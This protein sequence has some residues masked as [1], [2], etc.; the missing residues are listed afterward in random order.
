MTELSVTPIAEG[1]TADAAFEA[2]AGTTDAAF[3]LDG[4]NSLPSY[5]GVGTTVELAPPILPGLRRAFTSMRDTDRTVLGLVGWLSYDLGAETVGL[6]I[7][8]ADGM[9][10]SFMEV[11]ETLAIDPNGTVSLI[12]RH[13]SSCKLHA[14]IREIREQLSRP[15]DPT[16]SEAPCGVVDSVRWD[17]TD[18]EYADKIIKCQ[19]HIRAGDA[20][21][22]CL[23][24]RITVQASMEPLSVYRRLRQSNGTSRSGI[25]RIGDT[26]ILSTSPEQFL[27]VNEH[28]VISTSPI[29]GT[30]PRSD[31]PVE[32]EC[33]RIELQNNLKERAENIMI[34]DLMRN[35]LSRVCD[36]GTVTVTRLLEVE[37]H[38]QVHQ[39]VSTVEGQLR[40][41]NDT[42]DALAVCF[43][44][45]SMTG[46]PKKRA[47]ELLQ[48]LECGPRGL[49]AGAF[50][51]IRFDGVADFSMTIRTIVCT[52]DTAV[53]GTGGGITA[54]SVP[55]QEVNEI[56]LKARA[57][58]AAIEARA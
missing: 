33:L 1:I 14:R 55:Q 6:E 28:R 30:R 58:I 17:D 45:G 10:T 52:R 54:L 42:V 25:I 48:H 47:M 49:Y 40:A 12:T 34:V 20:Y 29:K 46:A 38:P 23:T 36:T 18:N 56:H 13:R 57:L 41:D 50:G 3:W 15:P 8:Q 43:P 35:D 16:L 5:V 32:D 37:S 9:H 24:T 27:S 31:D 26:W 2:L 19:E 21:Q 51:Y 7:G 4:G 22:L 39:L 53:I 44:A 11:R